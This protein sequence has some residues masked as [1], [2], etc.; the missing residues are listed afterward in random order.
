ML[1]GEITVGQKSTTVRIAF[2]SFII[3][4]SKKFVHIHFHSHCFCKLFEY[5]YPCIQIRST[6]VGMCHGNCITC[7]C[8]YH[9]DFFVWFGKCLLKNDHC[10]YGSTC[11]NISCTLFYAVGCHHT[12]S[13]I[14]LRR[15]HRYS[16][17][18][19]TSRIKESGSFLRQ[20]TGILSCNHNFRHNIAKFPRKSVRFYQTVKLIN[21]LLVVIFRL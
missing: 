10:K 4:G 9:I 5:I 3:E 21:H 17:L 19:F 14:A 6:V 18:Q 11:G 16:G 13:C 20:S 1:S 2:H 15:A 8:S 12:G 7:R